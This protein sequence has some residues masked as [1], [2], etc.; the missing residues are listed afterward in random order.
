MW[1]H[2]V[3]ITTC[4]PLA[5]Q[6]PL[7]PFQPIAHICYTKTVTTVSGCARNPGKPQRQAGNAPLSKQLQRPPPGLHQQTTGHYLSFSG[8]QDGGTPSFPTDV[9]RRYAC[10][11]CASGEELRLATAMH[12]GR[13][14]P[15]DKEQHVVGYCTNPKPCMALVRRAQA[16][17]PLA[18]RLHGKLALQGEGTGARSRAA[19]ER[20]CK[21]LCHLLGGALQVV[22]QERAA[23]VHLRAEPVRSSAETTAP[24]CS[25]RCSTSAWLAV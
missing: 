17:E 3:C 7:K 22:V 14:T 2:S 8:T 9:P 24:R 12:L 6:R 15:P 10:S 18:W 25:A 4:I 19:R 21:P 13:A 1:D 5:T 20:P 11:N 16:S 23:G